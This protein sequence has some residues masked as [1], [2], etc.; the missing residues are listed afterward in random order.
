MKS[1][2]LR[3][4]KTTYLK[5]SALLI[6]T[7]GIT[8]M[9]HAQDESAKHN[10]DADRYANSNMIISSTPGHVREHVATNWR[11][12]HYEMTL[13]NNKMT[14]FYAEGEKIPEA[15]WGDY[16][17]I[18][19]GIREQL[20]KDKIQAKKDQEQALL[21]QAQAKLDQEQAVRDQQQAKHDQEEAAKDEEQ[22]KRDQEQAA[23]DEAQAARDQVQAKH[24]QEEAAE[25]QRQM[26]LLL[27]DLVA[28]KIV[29]NAKSVH[30]LTLN[31]YEMKV[32]GVKQPDDIFKKYRD[33]YPRFS[34]GNFSYGDESGSGDIHMSRQ[35]VGN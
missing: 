15:R 26:K 34:K 18:I 24:D 28:D 13:L 29:P 20:H 9:A 4:M 17:N 23:G 11:G 22:A 33:K 5:S 30:E 31:F 32:N 19:T 35:S 8:I 14:D 3:T 6:A 10:L 7:I 1:N 2:Q 27:A 21:D 16:K 12:K 25:D